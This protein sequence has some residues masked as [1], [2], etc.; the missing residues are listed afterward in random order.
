MIIYN[1]TFHID[2]E[3]K[4]EGVAYLKEVYLPEAADSG[5]LQNPLL[6]RIIQEEVGEGVNYSVQFHVKDIDALNRW[7]ESEGR[8]LQQKL[9]TRFGYKIAGFTTLLEEIDWKK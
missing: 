2:N 1:T 5:A 8:L 7:L 3:V 6:R 4:E 9:M